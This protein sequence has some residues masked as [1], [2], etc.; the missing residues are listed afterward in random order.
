MGD[1]LTTD[2]PPAGDAASSAF[3]ILGVVVVVGV[4][5]SGPASRPLFS[6]FFARRMA[7]RGCQ[8]ALVGFSGAQPPPTRSYSTPLMTL[9][10]GADLP[11]REDDEGEGA[12]KGEAAGAGG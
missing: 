10:T 6:I 4:V 3:C 7:S 12:E 1:D 9:V 8:S 5:V 11:P 2:A